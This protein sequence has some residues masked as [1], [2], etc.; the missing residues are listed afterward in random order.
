MHRVLLHL[1]E[2][3]ALEYVAEEA[4]M[5][6]L[7]TLEVILEGLSFSLEQPHFSEGQSSVQSVADLIEVEDLL[8]DVLRVEVFHQIGVFVFFDS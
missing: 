8:V 6:L 2:D 4:L 5:G 7:E 1:V 3:I